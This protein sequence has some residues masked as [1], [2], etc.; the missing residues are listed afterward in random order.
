MLRLQTSG[1]LHGVVHDHDEDDEID[2]T[3]ENDD[4]G[5][6]DEYDE[7]DKNDDTETDK[8]DETDE[9]DESDE[10]DEDDDDDETDEH[11]ETD[12]H[13]D[14]ADAD[15]GDDDDDVGLGYAHPID[16]GDG[17]SHDSRW[18]NPADPSLSAL[19]Q[20]FHVKTNSKISPAGFKID[21]KANGQKLHFSVSWELENR[22]LEKNKKQT[23]T[24]WEK[25]NHQRWPSREATTTRRRHFFFRVH[26]SRGF[27]TPIWGPVV[28]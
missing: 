11:D 25:R 14:A 22:H 10:T 27:L 13:A 4:T 2:E 18:S 8:Y 6:Y 1:K 23:F 9:D 16:S 26:A 5:E 7:I 17:H 3:D 15:A 24:F 12:S 20:D 28:K 21:T 19:W